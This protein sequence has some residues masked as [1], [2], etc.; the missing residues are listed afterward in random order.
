M[1]QK[2]EKYARSLERRVEAC[3]TTVYKL[4]MCM[5]EGDRFQDAM[6]AIQDKEVVAETTRQIDRHQ[7]EIERLKRRG[8]LIARILF[9]LA[10][11]LVVIFLTSFTGK[12][13]QVSKSTEKIT[14]ESQLQAQLL[15]EQVP[16]VTEDYENQ[17]IEQALCKQGYYRDDIPLSYDMQDVMQSACSCYGVPYSLALA[18]CETESGFDPDAV[19]GKCTGYMQ[20]HR[21]NFPYLRDKT[22]YD[23]ESPDGNIVCG[24]CLLGELLDKYGGD[25]TRALMAY[26]AGETGAARQWKKGITS[27][28]YTRTVLSRTDQWKQQFNN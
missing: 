26:N 21:I 18:V 8:Y 13:T 6:M 7:R 11:I 4:C 23:P 2:K 16:E 10:L 5:D 19:N 20:I 1:S 25:T 27:T 28:Q 3:E 17:K 24:V 12:N 9:I 14:T 15:C 22:G